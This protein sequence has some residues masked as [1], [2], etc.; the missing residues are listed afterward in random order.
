M[1]DNIN[2]AKRYLDKSKD[3]IFSLATGS[4]ALSIT[5]RQSLAPEGAVELHYL[6]T[7]W[8][9]LLV[10]I[11]GYILGLFMRAGVHLVLF[12]DSSPGK[13][14]Q[15]AINVVNLIALILL[16]GGFSQGLLTLT[17]FAI[18]NVA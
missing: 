18:A 5:F 16:I 13:V 7:A 8:L 17:L 10:C 15:I 11:F 6:T 12:W 1:N 4:L 9:S 14:L 3:V 2:E